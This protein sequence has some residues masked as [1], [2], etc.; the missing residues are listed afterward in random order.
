MLR[1]NSNNVYFKHNQPEEQTG[2][3]RFLPKIPMLSEINYPVLASTG[4][5]T[6]AAL[7]LIAKHQGKGI[8]ELAQIDYHLKEVL[9]IGAGSM[10]G[11][12]ISGLIMDKGEHI[13]KKLEEANFQ[14]LNNLLLPT[15]FVERGLH[16]ANKSENKFIKSLMKG[17]KT[18]TSAFI[19]IIGIVGGMHIGGFIANKINNKFLNEESQE[20]IRNIKLKDY[21]V[22]VDDI[23]VVLAVQNVQMI[24]K[25]VPA[26][27]LTCGYEVGTKN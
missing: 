10:A 2:E 9:A 6:A 11:G 20:R 18:F 1:I 27:F 19:A 25:I 22:H 24:N 3:R 21:A 4:I 26:C 17:H 14:F 16:Y 12:F 5:G 15:V 8:K 23:P 7:L 13:R